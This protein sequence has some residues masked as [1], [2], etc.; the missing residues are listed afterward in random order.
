MLNRF[1]SM[2]DSPY[3]AK[4]PYAQPLVTHITITAYFF[5]KYFSSPSSTPPKHQS[6]HPVFLSSTQ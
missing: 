3:N 5:F 2:S 1:A 4:I 6:I